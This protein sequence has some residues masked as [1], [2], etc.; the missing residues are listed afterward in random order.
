[1]QMPVDFELMQKKQQSSSQPPTG[2][3]APHH[4]GVA[5]RLDRSAE[6]IL[7]LRA[8]NI[9]SLIHALFTA[10]RSGKREVSL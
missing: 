7:Q 3:K 4:A 6:G 2:R 10:F 8:V 5:E 1:M 9:F